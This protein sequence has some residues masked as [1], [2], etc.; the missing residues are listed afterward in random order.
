MAYALQSMLK[1]R[2]MRQDRTQTELA[3]ARVARNKAAQ[4]LDRRRDEHA[5]YEAEKDERRDRVYAA[6]M[7]RPVKMEELDMARTAVTRIDE[8]GILLEEAERKAVRAL[9]ERER[10]TEG[11]RLKFVEATREYTKIEEHRK[12]WLEE[13]Q[14]EQE[15]AADSEMEEFAGRR[16]GCD[17]DDTDA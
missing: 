17:D 14:R 15:R 6:L 13:S 12:I 1:I 9:E 16:M 7:G 5:R 8:E 3:H 4:E 11:A 10:E 2:G